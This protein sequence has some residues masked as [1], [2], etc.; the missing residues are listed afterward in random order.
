VER[1]LSD[2][3]GRI[4]AAR[5]QGS[6]WPAES[7]VAA[8]VAM[9]DGYN[10]RAHAANERA[11]RDRADYDHFNREAARYNLMLVYPDGMDEHAAVK[12]KAVAAR[13]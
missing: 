3:E 13:E 12:P 4:A 10:Q 5:A 1:A 9:R 8:A 11:A 6:G 7:E 2:L